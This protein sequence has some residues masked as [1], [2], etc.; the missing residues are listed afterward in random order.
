MTGLGSRRKGQAGER[1]V[2]ALI[3]DLLGVDARRAVRQHA[4][5]S[6]ILGVP[7]WSLEVK[8]QDKPLIRQWWAQTVEQ[9]EEASLLPALFYRLPRRSWRVLWPLSCV[10]VQQRSPDWLAVEYAADTTPEAWA[11]VVREVQSG[12]RFA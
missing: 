9:A 8:R 3:R 12:E 10:M 11:A 6:D 5:D 7:G 2:V 4:G 1:E